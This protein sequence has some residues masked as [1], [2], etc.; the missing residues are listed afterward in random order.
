MEDHALIFCAYCLFGNLSA[1]LS[2]LF[3]GAV[4]VVLVSAEEDKGLLDEYVGGEDSRW[5][6]PDPPGR[7]WR[8][9]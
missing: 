9:G 1:T 3:G 7:E 6:S 2:T 5:L 4:S 8:D